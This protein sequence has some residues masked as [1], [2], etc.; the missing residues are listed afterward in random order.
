MA[1]AA[2]ENSDYVIITSDNPRTEN[3]NTIIEDIIPGISGKNTPCAIIP[4]RT[5]AIEYSLKNARKD[6]VIVLCG[7]GHETYQEIGGRMLPM[8]EREIVQALL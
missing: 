3:P 7:K 1:Q 6:D 4:D 2:V 5:H 8:D